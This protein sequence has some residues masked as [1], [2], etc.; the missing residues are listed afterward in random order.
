[1]DNNGP[2]HQNV[3]V[4]VVD[5]YLAIYRAVQVHTNPAF[6]AYHLVKDLSL[7]NM[8]NVCRRWVIN[9]DSGKQEG[10]LAAL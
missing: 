8:V 9:C 5:E 1:M 7:D 6:R 10:R 4:V 2:H 3:V